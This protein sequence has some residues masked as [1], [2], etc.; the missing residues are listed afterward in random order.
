MKINKRRERKKSLFALGAA[1][2]VLLILTRVISWLF[3]HKVYAV[4]DRKE[5][6]ARQIGG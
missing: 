1:A 6:R 3:P 4:V 5:A 2:G